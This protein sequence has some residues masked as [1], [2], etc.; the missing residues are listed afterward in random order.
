MAIVRVCCPNTGQNE[1]GDNVRDKLCNVSKRHIVILMDF[2]AVT[3][4][5]LDWSRLTAT[6]EVPHCTLR[7]LTGE[8]DVVDIW[9]EKNPIKQDF[10][11]FHII[12]K[13]ILELIT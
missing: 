3:N 1:F 11:F 7:M 10:T 12:T 4:K 2:N 13:H 6:P 8:L 5:E 9:R